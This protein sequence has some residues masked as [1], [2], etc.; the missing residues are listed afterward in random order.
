MMLRKHNW[1]NT[2]KTRAYY[3]S[4]YNSMWLVANDII[5]GLAIGSFLAANSKI[6]AYKLHKILQVN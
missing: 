2:A 3:I 1:A 5:I 6:M 4:F